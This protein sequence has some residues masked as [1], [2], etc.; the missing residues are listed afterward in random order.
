M[1]YA[2]GFEPPRRIQE[3]LNDGRRFAL[4]GNTP[5][6]AMRQDDQGEVETS[7]Q[8][9]KITL[10][11]KMSN[12]QR[13]DLNRLLQRQ[14]DRSSS[15]YHKWLTP[16]EYADRFG[17]N[18]RD[19]QRVSQW[20]QNQGLTVA[21]IP[22]SRTWITVAGT[23]TAVRYAF[24]TSI[25]RYS[26]N[27]RNHYANSSDPVLPRA[28]Q[29]VVEGIRGLNDFNL[30]PHVVR[31]NTVSVVPKFTSNISGS[32]FIAPDDFATIY[33]IHTLYNSGIDGTGEKIAVAGQTDIDL[34]DIRAF[35]AA[36]GLSANDPQIVLDGDDPGTIADD[37]AEADL[38][39]EWAGAVARN[40][41]VIYV[42]SSDVLNSAVYAIDNNVAPVLSI[43]YGLC[44]AQFGA[45]SANSLSSI[46]QQA[47]AQGITI[48]TASGDSGAADCDYQTSTSSP[49]VTA[50]THGLA[51]DMPASS[52][53]V[54]AMGGTTL[55][56]GS[57]TYWNTTNN[58]S[59][60]SAIS[61]IPEIAWN[62]TSL[63]SEL[64]ASGGGKSSFF[65]KPSWQKGANVPN[66]AAR[67][68][69][70]LAL[71]SS[72][73]HDGFLICSSG[74]CVNGFRNTD[75]SLTVVGGTSVAAPSFAGIVVLLNQQT[76]TSQ[77][78]INANLYSLASFSPDA[79]HDI[80]SGNNQV[81]CTEASPDCPT[82]GVIGYSAGTGYDQVTGLG[83]I[84]ALNLINEW[85]S[86]FQIA[87]NQTAL[88]VPRGT[89]GTAAV[90]ITA[91]NNFP[92]R[93]SFECTVPSAF[94]NV[95]CTV[96]GTVLRSGTT[97]LTITAPSVAS[98][99][100]FPPYGMF[101]NR[102]SLWLSIGVACT[103][104]LAIP[105]W[106]RRTRAL[107]GLTVLS[108]TIM[109]GC[110]DEGSSTPVVETMQPP[111]TTASITVTA[112]SGVLQHTASFSLTVP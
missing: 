13:A 22:R 42:N 18:Q 85:A 57:G 46:F 99:P 74:S 60:G 68:V 105:S 6:A 92:G 71:S 76:K 10:H 44:E 73:N 107:L 41:T 65:A 78:N 88:T 52:P 106:Q 23:A 20:L 27:G 51:V 108:M 4:A 62:D 104:L 16:E 12:A 61:Y 89:S 26:V 111:S 101:S 53:N 100:K 24:Q 43:S 36:A 56:E 2:S 75:T 81:P 70:D 9:K 19:L 55:Q 69:P 58:S 11:F 86:D 40:A 93:V 54:T 37:E 64:T 98:L 79:F 39:I 67:D 91:V 47:N 97:T 15:D 48:V 32:H 110:G 35:R 1:K 3:D 82:G 17:M 95:T 49:P 25:H 109:A 66:D 84:D 33:N 80:T 94:T 14:Q 96:P 29:G 8:I 7:F 103:L 59:N 38:D 5:P 28:L 21:E 87:I 63:V 34:A 83:S 112:T 77:G 102:G 30:K 50:A 31:S 45:A 90:N 72:P